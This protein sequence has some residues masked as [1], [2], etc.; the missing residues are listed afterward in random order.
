MLEQDDN[1]EFFKEISL[2]ELCGA[3][4]TFQKRQNSG[5]DGWT[6]DF[7]RY[8][9]ELVGKDLLLVLEEI[10]KEGKIKQ[11]FNTTFLALIPKIDLPATFED[12]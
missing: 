5:P 8:F 1:R 3:L 6:I 12:L 4:D 2:E 7:Y 10:R 11:A 9:F